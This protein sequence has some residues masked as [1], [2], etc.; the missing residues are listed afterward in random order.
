MRPYRAL[1]LAAAALL[2]FPATRAAAQNPRPRAE[3]GRRVE[4]L[5]EG[6]ALTPAQRAKID[7]IE[8]HYRGQMPSFTPGSPPDSAT[9]A[10]IRDLF[11]RLRDDIRAVLTPDQQQVFDRHAEEMR[12]RRSGGP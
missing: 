4:M 1:T 2:A 8:A 6:I 9:R 10:K 12:E 11:R 7:S 5:L 3:R